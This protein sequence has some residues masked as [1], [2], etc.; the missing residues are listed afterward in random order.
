MARPCRPAIAAFMLGLLAVPLRAQCPDGTPPP[1]A[2]AARVAP[3]PAATSVAVLYFDNLSRDTGDA[4]VA[5]GLTEELISRLGQIARL[6]VK[7][8]TAVQRYRGKPIDDPTSLGHTLGVAHLVSGSVRRGGNRLRVTVEMTR[9]TNGVRVWGDTYERSS[10]DLMAVEADIAQAIAEGVGGQL[11]PTER[12]SLTVRPTTN[13]EAYDHY[14]RG[15]YAIAQRTPAAARR[16][17]AEYESAVRLDPGFAR[18]YGRIGLTYALAYDWG[19]PIPGLSVDS[20]LALGHTAADRAL[21]LD[22]LSADAWMADAAIRRYLHPTTY[23]GSVASF[24]RALALDP[25]NAEVWHQYAG[26][27]VYLGRDSLAMVAYR[28][29]LA[30]EPERAV[31]WENVEFA[32]YVRRRF[33]EAELL[34]DSGL[35]VDPQ[36][37]YLHADKAVLALVRGDTAGARVSIAAAVATRPADF[38]YWTE[39][40]VAALEARTGD[41]AAARARMQRL[42]DQMPNPQHPGDFIGTSVALGF[43]RIGDAARTLDL[44][45]SIRPRGLNLSYFLLDP[46]FDLVRSDPRFQRLV[47]ETRPP[48]TGQ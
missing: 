14:L 38:P 42:A 34:A 8:R 45:E 15:N 12:R 41:S 3:S 33:A 7:S 24:E 23:E 46:G 10:S 31:T 36:A 11:A 2:R 13:P 20:V 29:A 5:D 35:A 37:Y 19:W 9:V 44:L 6:Q 47:A 22:T 16:A 18:A 4:Y 21:L 39:P 26:T 17:I 43:A 27:L 48:G 28:R 1:C 32:R 40:V 30:L 25:R